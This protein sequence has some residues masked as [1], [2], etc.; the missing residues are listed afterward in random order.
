MEEKDNQWPLWEVFIQSKSGQPYKHAGS[1]HAPDGEMALQNARDI[2]TRRNEGTSIWVVPAQYIIA[3]TPEE[4]GS[5][6]DPANDKVYRHPTF[7]TVPEG[8]KYI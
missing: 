7:Y 2:Y 3:S 5:F 4:V 6:F 1:V 8:V